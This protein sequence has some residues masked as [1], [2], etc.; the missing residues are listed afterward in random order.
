[1]KIKDNE[2]NLE[3]HLLFKKVWE[4]SMLFWDKIFE[5]ELIKNKVNWIISLNIKKVKQ[6]GKR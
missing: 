3:K 5:I 1:M 6:N 4:Y 2:S